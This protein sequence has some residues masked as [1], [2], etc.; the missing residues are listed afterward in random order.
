[1]NWIHHRMIQDSKV[2]MSN[3]FIGVPVGHSVL[4]AGV[5]TRHLF[6]LTLSRRKTRVSISCWY[7]SAKGVEIESIDNKCGFIGKKIG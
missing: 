3:L 1:M 7:T 2:P 6:I 4:S 5:R